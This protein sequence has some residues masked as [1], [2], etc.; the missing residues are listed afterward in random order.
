MVSKIVIFKEKHGDYYYDASTPE[1]FNKV[2]L[3]VLRERFEA[4]YWYYGPSELTPLSAEDQAI[5]DLTDEQVEALPEALKET[6]ATK[7]NRILRG[8]RARQ[9]EYDRDKQWMDTLQE[10][11]ALPVEE[12]LVHEIEVGNRGRKALTATSFITE[13]ADYQYE[14][15][16]VEELRTV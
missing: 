10:L 9:A 16:E 2:A 6:T 1:I 15:F 14:G 8:V 5:A 13:R 7:R 3:A 12:A 11:L 4:G